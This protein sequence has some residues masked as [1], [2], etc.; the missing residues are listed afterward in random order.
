MRLLL[1]LDALYKPWRA[2]PAGRLVFPLPITTYFQSRYSKSKLSDMSRNEEKGHRYKLWKKLQ[3]DPAPSTRA[4]MFDKASEYKFL[5]T[6]EEKGSNV[7]PTVAVIPLKK[8]YAMEKMR[9]NNSKKFLLLFA[10]M[11][12]MMA[13][14]LPLED[15][16]DLDFD[17]GEG[18]PILRG[19]MQSLI[20]TIGQDI[21]NCY[22]LCD[23]YTSETIVRKVFKA[24][25][26][27]DALTACAQLFVRHRRDIMQ[28][29]AAHAA[30]GVDELQKGQQD[31]QRRHAIHYVDTMRDI[32]L[33]CFEKLR[34][35]S[36]RDLTQ[37]V[38]RFGGSAKILTNDKALEE[39]YLKS[40][41]QNKA[42]EQKDL[43]SRVQAKGKLD[44][45]E[46]KKELSRSVED[47]IKENQE[48]F[49]SKMRLMDQ[50]I[51]DTVAQTGDRII[52][53]LTE[54]TWDLIKDPDQRASIRSAHF[55]LALRDYYQINSSTLERTASG[56]ESIPETSERTSMDPNPAAAVPRKPVRFLTLPTQN[57]T[58]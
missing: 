48:R 28:A 22:N 7:A 14:L 45:Q 2:S 30:H 56:L 57:P 20:D 15:I 42:T 31:L 19:R 24:S 52:K 16:H 21:E 4:K 55:F 46:L 17:L 1:R 23:R 58:A 38:V 33:K 27:D 25:D 29:L 12:D 47:S 34:T 11:I 9:R 44:F 43:S 35:K 8:V 6:S 18:L 54:D 49:R 39:V 40:Q 5:Y 50:N 37:L 32:L 26:W 13:E 51:T 36:E 41:R 10:E 53:T 3:V